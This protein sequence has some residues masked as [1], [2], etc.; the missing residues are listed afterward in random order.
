MRDGLRAIH[1]AGPGEDELAA[2]APCGQSAAAR[3]GDGN[4]DPSAD[5]RRARHQS[6][7]DGHGQVP[8]DRSLPRQAQVYHET[9]GA[10]PIEARICEMVKIEWGVAYERGGITACESERAA[11]Q[12][13]ASS[14]G[15]LVY[16]RTWITS[17]V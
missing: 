6:R 3:G 5:I 10:G 7:R 17:W 9:T 16:R 13:Q 12:L 15:E 8:A 14:G 2:E 4:Y 1:G 11:R